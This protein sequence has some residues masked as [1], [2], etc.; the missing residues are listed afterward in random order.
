MSVNKIKSKIGTDLYIQLKELKLSTKHILFLAYYTSNGFNG[1]EAF[2]KVASNK[3]IKPEVAST[4]ASEYLRLPNMRAGLKIIIDSYLTECK[5]TFE[6]Q[7]IEQLRV[8]AFYNPLDIVD[9]KGEL[10]Y[11]S[12]DDIPEHLRQCIDGIETRQYGK[13]GDISRT[14]FKLANRDKA[15]DELAKYIKILNTTIEHT[16]KDG[17]PIKIQKDINNLDDKALQKIIE[18]NKD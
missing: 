18:S 14:V 12:G 1:R 2:E 8:R 3:K 9:E 7:I 15:R 16:G 10:K 13:D 17:G 11:K 5:D 4:C 6:K